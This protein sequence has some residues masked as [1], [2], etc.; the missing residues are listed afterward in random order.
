MPTNTHFKQ[1]TLAEIQAILFDIS[2]PLDGLVCKRIATLEENLIIPLNDGVETE[3]QYNNGQ[4]RSSNISSDKQGWTRGS[5]NDNNRSSGQSRRP[6]SNH[7]NSR[8]RPSNARSSLSDSSSRTKDSE[9]SMECWE[10][11]RNFKATEFA[12]SEGIQKIKNEISGIFNKLSSNKTWSIQKIA[13][14]EKLEGLLGFTVDSRES[15]F[16]TAAFRELAQHIFTLSSSN[17]MMVGIQAELY[18]DLIQLSPIFNEIIYENIKSYRI[19]MHEI[20]YVDPEEDYDAFC[21]Y[22]KKN[23]TRKSTILFIVHLMLNDII[24]KETVLQ[25]VVD[26]FVFVN[27]F[28]ELEGKGK[29]VDE[30][31]ENIF[32]IVSSAYACVKDHTLWINDAHPVIIEI[33]KKKSKDYKS[34]SSRAIFKYMDLMDMI[35]KSTV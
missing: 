8:S 5:A 2:C 26:F 16:D 7:G 12:V 4:K 25:I 6:S 29:E 30:I 10:S 34:L 14:L 28:I 11:V 21:A 35:K 3:F 23:D 20:H 27:E 22:N 24:E 15:S 33:S 13:V 17:K 9:M 18:R 31:S 1:Y 19:M 32:L